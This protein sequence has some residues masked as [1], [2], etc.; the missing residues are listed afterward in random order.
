V[1]SIFSSLLTQLFRAALAVS[2]PRAPASSVFPPAQC[3]GG[4]SVPP[5]HRGSIGNPPSL[6]GFA[7]PTMGITLYGAISAPHK[8]HQFLMPFVSENS[9][10]TLSQPELGTRRA[11][12]PRHLLQQ[13]LLLDLRRCELRR[14]LTSG[15]PLI[16]SLLPRLR[17]FLC[18]PAPPISARA[19]TARPGTGPHH[20][21]LGQGTLVGWQPLLCRHQQPRS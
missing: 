21:R 10:S 5:E 15:L 11:R 1:A 2:G 14:G 16:C 20:L 8:R 4:I 9:E 17:R 13:L 19:S 18:P 3:T 6:R 7:Q 12:R